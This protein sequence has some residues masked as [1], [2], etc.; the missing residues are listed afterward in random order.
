ME[1]HYH[2]Q[3][4]CPVHP[5]LQGGGG[6]EEE[7]RPLPHKYYQIEKPRTRVMGAGLKEVNT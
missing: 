7:E 5:A 1:W 6:G 3:W 2:L 4:H